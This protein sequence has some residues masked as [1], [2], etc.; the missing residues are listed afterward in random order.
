MQKDLVRCRLSGT[1]KRT[2]VK[3]TAH[4]LRYTFATQLVNAGCDVT[5][6]QQLL[7]HK[8]LTTTMIYTH[9]HD[10]TVIEDYFQAMA[11]IEGDQEA[12]LEGKTA[13]DKAC[14]L[15]DEMVQQELS[16]EQ[17]QILDEVRRF[18]SQEV[19]RTSETDDI[20]GC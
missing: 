10:K 19:M 4:M 8:C 15:L 2:G 18:L 1:G 3:I 11:Q 9:V 12:I 16:H 20:D 7:G 14:S 17:Q 5:T 6:I 13:I